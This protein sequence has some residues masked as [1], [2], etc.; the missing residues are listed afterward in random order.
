[1]IYTSATIVFDVR[2]SNLTHRGI[3]RTD[4][5]AIIRH[6]AYTSKNIGWWLGIFLVV[7]YLYF[8]DAATFKFVFLS[9]ISLMAQ[10]YW[11]YMRAITEERHLSIDPAYQ[12][13]CN[14]VKYRF[15]PGII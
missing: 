9:T 15:I 11:Y 10:S 6:P 2:F 13:Y 12:T 5:F 4:P 1:M 3:I 7:L 14:E 8:T